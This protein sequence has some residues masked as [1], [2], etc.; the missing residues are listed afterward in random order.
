MKNSVRV[1]DDPV[2]IAGVTGPTV[3][4]FWMI[5]MSNVDGVIVVSVDAYTLSHNRSAFFRSHLARA[6]FMASSCRSASV[7]LSACARPPLR[8]PRRPRATAK[9]LSLPGW[10]HLLDATDEVGAH[11]VLVSSLPVPQGLDGSVLCMT[12][13]AYRSIARRTVRRG[14]PKIAFKTGP[15]LSV[16]ER[17]GVQGVPRSLTPAAEAST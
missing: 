3:A 4:C 1:A 9:G 2:P 15:H 7:S 14:T 13:R 12:A 8:P 6:A 11:L 17:R 5:L 16:R 10:F